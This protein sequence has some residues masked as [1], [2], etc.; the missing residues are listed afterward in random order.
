MERKGTSLK[1]ALA[2]GL[3]CQIGE[4]RIHI[5]VRLRVCYSSAL[6]RLR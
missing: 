6:E 4:N 1:G 2:H 3:V 5:D